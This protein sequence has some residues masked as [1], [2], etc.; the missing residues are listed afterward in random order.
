MS[1]ETLSGTKDALT[2]QDLCDYLPHGVMFYGGGTFATLVGLS[3]KKA[4]LRHPMGVEAID[5]DELHIENDLILRPLSELNEEI[6]HNGE[7]I[8]PI[9]EI[10]YHHN[11]SML[12][13]DQI[14]SDPKRYP[15]TVV[16]ALLSWHFDVHGLIEKGL[17]VS[18]KELN[19]EKEG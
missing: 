8:V 16:Q 11:F 4:M 5:I 12:N 1:K 10:G 17:A 14:I 3:E 9:E 13:T 7:K 18:M 2:L 6:E 19:K 15:F